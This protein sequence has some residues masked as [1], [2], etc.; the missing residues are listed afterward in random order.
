[1]Y[2]NDEKRALADKWQGWTDFLQYGTLALLLVSVFVLDALPKE[3]AKA[4]IWYW[5]AG[6]FI[7]ATAA[8]LVSRKALKYQMTYLNAE[9]KRIGG[10]F[11]KA[12]EAFKKD[13]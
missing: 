5:A 1:M 8:F 11:D 4:I 6:M 3:T 2:R 13:K 9:G 10:L 7:L 12:I